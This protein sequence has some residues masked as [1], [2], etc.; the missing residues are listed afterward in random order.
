MA[1]QIDT[2]LIRAPLKK[3]YNY[4]ALFICAFVKGVWIVLLSALA[5]RGANNS[6]NTKIRRK[7]DRQFTGRNLPYKA[8]GD[9]TYAF[10][11]LDEVGTSD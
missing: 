8:G 4:N 2:P 3:P 6:N 5:N 11:S 7:V 1:Q 10:N 9:L